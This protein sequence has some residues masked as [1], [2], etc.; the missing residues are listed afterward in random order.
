MTDYDIIIIYTPPSSILSDPILFG[1]IE[2][3]AGQAKERIE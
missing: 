2:L 3:R 1:G